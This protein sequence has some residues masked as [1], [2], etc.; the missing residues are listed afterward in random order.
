VPFRQLAYLPDRRSTRIEQPV[1]ITVRGIDTSR[2]PYQ[3]MVSTRSISCHG[4]RYLSRNKVLPGDIATL[5]VIDPRAGTSKFPTQARVKSVKQLAAEEMLFDVAVE[6]E[7]PHDI[8]R[9]A[10]PPEDWAEF[11]TVETFGGSPR[12]LQIVRRPQGTRLSEPRRIPAGPIWRFSSLETRSTSPLPPFLAQLAAN[13]G[14]EIPATAA[15]RD[16]VAVGEGADESVYEFCS[17]LERKAM[18]VFEG[19]VRAFVKELKSRSE[20]IDEPEA[21]SAFSTCPRWSGDS[22]RK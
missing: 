16:S 12:E 3:E 5:E 21:A 13:L 8:W 10:S 22:S 2:V 14:D 9:I 4:C 1:H 11:S 19:L 6:L 15:A 17:Q 20:Q 18:T 7:F